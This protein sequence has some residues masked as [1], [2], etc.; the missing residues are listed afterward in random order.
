TTILRVQFYKNDKAIVSGSGDGTIKISN[1][2]DDKESATL[3]PLAK[4]DWAVVTRDGRFDASSGGMEL[5]HFNVGNQL[6]RLEQFKDRFY[7]PGLLSK[8]TGFNKQPLRDTSGFDNVKLYPKVSCDLTPDN[9][10]LRIKMTDQGGGIGKVIVKVNGK[11]Y[12]V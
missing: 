8:L 6:V 12:D 2:S 1:L 11:M 10:S 9:K 7:E 3:C 4:D 5:M